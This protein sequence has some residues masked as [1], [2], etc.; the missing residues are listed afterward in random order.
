MKSIKLI[1][2]LF[3]IFTA[4]TF[5]SCDN[6][7]IDSSIELNN[8]GNNGGG[9]NGG[10][11]NG[12]G[13][14]STGDYWPAALNNQWV[15]KLDGVQ[16][17]PMKIIS[18]N[19]IS[20]STYY[21]FDTLFGQGSMGTVGSATTRMKKNSG[22]YYLKIEDL[23]LNLGNNLTATM[24]GFEYVILK[25]YLAVGQTWNGVY[26]Q[27]TNYSD[28]Q[29]PDITQTTNYTGTIVEKDATVTINGAS[30]TNVIKLRI[31]QSTTFPGLP[32]PTVADSDYWF[33]KD[34]GPIKAVTV[35]QGSTTTNELMSFIL[36]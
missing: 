25:D 32:T 6:E 21:T 35:S 18:I 11:N 33:A 2:G 4:F 17:P 30:Y 8:G 19:S 16:Q 15:F 34:V 20:G 12:G 9:N 7:P 29:I 24:T 1:V 5:T 14:T 26:T 10:G 28:P 13:G 3:L 31:S 27:T 22:D 23:N 36:N